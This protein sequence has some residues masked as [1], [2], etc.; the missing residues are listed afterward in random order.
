[1]L[2]AVAG[3]HADPGLPRE[4]QQQR[5]IGR[6]LDAKTQHLV[7]ARPL[8]FARETGGCV[9]DERI[10]PVDGA[11]QLREGLRAAIVPP[12]VGELV[13]KRRLPLLRRPGR[14]CRRHHHHR[15]EQAGHVRAAAVQRLAHVDGALQSQRAAD[16]TCFRDPL[17]GARRDP[18]D[19]DNPLN[20]QQNKNQSQSVP[21]VP[22][23]PMVP[24]AGC[25]GPGFQQFRV[26]RLVGPLEPHG[27]L[28]TS[29]NPD[30]WHLRHPWHHRHLIVGR[31]QEDRRE[32]HEDDREVPYQVTRRRRGAASSAAISDA[33]RARR[34]RAERSSR[35][36]FSVLLSAPD[37]SATTASSVLRP[38]AIQN[39]PARRP[40]AP[41]N[42]R[43]T[44]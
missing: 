15:S 28:G 26:P 42:R 35:G 22:T 30:P 11:R 19:T 9:P 29:W 14:G 10:E 38:T 41:P 20:N 8:A 39:R 12:D 3:V 31:A 37:R 2:S 7:V 40:L 44:F 6:R 5:R 4:I 36:P 13:N 34:R 1:M 25:H 43:K 18:R 24:R 17:A 33:R 32:H 21:K 16:V 23:V 27:T